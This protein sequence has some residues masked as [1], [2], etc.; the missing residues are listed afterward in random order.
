MGIS[1]HRP[2]ITRFSLPA[3]ASSSSILRRFIGEIAGETSLS[4]EEI[5]GLQVAVT[6]V[7]YDVLSQQRSLGEGRV[8]LRIDASDDEV[9]VDLAYRDTSFP[10]AEYFSLS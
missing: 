4:I 7:F 2:R 9:T 3:D 5:S 1:K 8:T 10:P 6:E